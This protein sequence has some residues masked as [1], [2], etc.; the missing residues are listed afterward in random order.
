MKIFS[1]VSVSGKTKCKGCI[2]G[3]SK[4]MYLNNYDKTTDIFS[5]KQTD[6]LI[7]YWLKI[8]NCKR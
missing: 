1:R 4:L 2:L 6:F 8:F 7:K 5:K 3:G